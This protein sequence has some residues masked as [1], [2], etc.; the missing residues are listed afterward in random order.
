MNKEN[1][2]FLVF[3]VATKLPKKIICFA[4]YTGFFFPIF[5]FWTLLHSMIVCLP[6]FCFFFSQKMYCIFF[7][8]LWDAFFWNSKNAIFPFRLCRQ[9][10]NKWLLQKWRTRKKKKSNCVDTLLYQETIRL[11]QLFLIIFCLYNHK[12]IHYIF[13]RQ[14]RNKKIFD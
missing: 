8:M 11:L 13:E 10:R 6:F 4:L 1:H 14:K 3:S 12:I 9:K 2:K 7:L 5:H